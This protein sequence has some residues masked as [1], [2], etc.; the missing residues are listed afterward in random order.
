MQP[1]GIMAFTVSLTEGYVDLLEAAYK[2]LVDKVRSQQY[3][4][5]IDNSFQTALA[6]C[7]YQKKELIPLQKKD[8]GTIYVIQPAAYP[9][10]HY[11]VNLM[12]Q[13]L[14]GISGLE[15]AGGI[16]VGIVNPP[17]AVV[18]PPVPIPVVQPAPPAQPVPPGGVSMVA[19]DG[20]ALPPPEQPAAPS[21][22]SVVDGMAGPYPSFSQVFHPGTDGV[23]PGPNPYPAI[24]PAPAYGQILAPPAGT[25]SCPVCQKAGGVGEMQQ[26]TCGHHMHYACILQLALVRKTWID[27]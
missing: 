3:Q 19:A 24:G 2:A 23:A 22:P 4:R 13:T 27:L 26:L 17:P 18:A 7:L 9:N 16:P 20:V 25:I 11:L 1:P 12:E 6:T 8:P 21:Q 10:S 15:A 14:P 5:V